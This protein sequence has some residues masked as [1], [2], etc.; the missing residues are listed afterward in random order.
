MDNNF[1][2]LVRRLKLWVVILAI[3]NITIVSTIAVNSYRSKKQEA[4][5]SSGTDGINSFFKNYLD[6]SDSQKSEFDS[7]FNDYIDKRKEVGS[8]LRDVKERLNEPGV[9]NDSVAMN[10][11]YE[12]FIAAQSLNRDLTVQLYSDIRAICSPVQVKQFNNI[13]SQTII[14]EEHHK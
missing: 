1:L 8:R 2:K 7:L 10:K 14:T 9:E 11:I 3:L 6:L 13:I 5:A 12:D 4:V